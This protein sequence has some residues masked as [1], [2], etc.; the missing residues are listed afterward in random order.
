MFVP[1]DGEAARMEGRMRR[2]ALW[3]VIVVVVVSVCFAS[4]RVT[5]GLI[6]GGVLSL[7]NHKWLSLSVRQMFADAEAKGV[8][9][10]LRLAGYVLRYFVIVIVVGAV[11]MSDLISLPATLIGLCSFVVAGFI[12][13]LTQIY[14]ML[15][16]RREV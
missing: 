2:S 10:K 12:E 16:K 11:Y 14:S 15:I 3:T 13:A 4:W 1:D 6:L 7:L 5:A 8:R 9:P